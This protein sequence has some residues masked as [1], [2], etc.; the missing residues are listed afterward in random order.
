M[1]DVLSV[2]LITIIIYNIIVGMKQ[3]STYNIIWSDIIY[4]GD[5]AMYPCKMNCIIIVVSHPHPPQHFDA[6]SPYFIGKGRHVCRH[7]SVIVMMIIYTCIFA[8][9]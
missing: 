3:H 6:T 8:I 4:L 2:K 9:K 7:Y 1:Y 5:H